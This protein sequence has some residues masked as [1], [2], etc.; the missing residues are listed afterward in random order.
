MWDA[1]KDAGREGIV[2]GVKWSVVLLIVGSALL[3]LAGDY[4]IVR[5]QAQNGQRAFQALSQAAAQ[6]ARPKE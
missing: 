4:R 3:W 6:Q 2:L 5:Q 1:V